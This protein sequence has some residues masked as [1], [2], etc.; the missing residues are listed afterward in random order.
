MAITDFEQ[1]VILDEMIL[2]FSLFGFAYTLH[3]QLS[4]QDHVLAALG[5]GL[6]F[7][8]LAFI[9]RGAIGGGDIKLIA[10][11]GLWL[12]TKA[13]LTIIIYGTIAGG[14]AASLLLLSKRIYRKQ[15][16]AYGPYFALSG[17]G[18]LLKWLHTIF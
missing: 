2:V 8:F 11:L 15:Y 14:I 12:G 1:Q 3:L 7:L 5:S 10:A 6:V 16:I 4:L 13:L 9:S 18:V 17:I